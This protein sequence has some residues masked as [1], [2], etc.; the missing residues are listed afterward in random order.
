MVEPKY[1]SFGDMRRKCRNIPSVD[2]G[3][4]QGNQRP[5]AFLEASVHHIRHFRPN[6]R[7]TAFQPPKF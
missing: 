7:Y 4:L 6:I 1:S 3:F 5:E 2:I